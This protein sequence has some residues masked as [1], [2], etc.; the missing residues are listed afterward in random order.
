MF[1]PFFFTIFS[2]DLESLNLYFKPKLILEKQTH[3][4]YNLK[5]LKSSIIFHGK[6]YQ[7]VKLVFFF[8]YNIYMQLLLLHQLLLPQSYKN[9]NILNLRVR[10][11]TNCMLT[12]LNIEKKIFMYFHSH[13]FLKFYSSVYNFLRI[14]TQIKHS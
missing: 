6:I 2:K 5:H 12:Q 3:F 1:L 10:S 13:F 14:V 7:S 9:R 4:L 8:H 11:E